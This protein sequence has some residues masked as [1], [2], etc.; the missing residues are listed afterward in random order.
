[1]KHQVEHVLSFFRSPILVILMGSIL[2]YTV[3]FSYFSIQR[4]TAFFSGFDL[5]NMDHTIWN[6]MQ[7]DFFT[8]NR[9]GSTFSRFSIHSDLILVLLAPFYFI[10]NDVRMLLVLQSFFLAL[11]AIPT[12]IIAKRLLKNDTFALLISLVYLLNPWLHWVNLYDFH[13]VALAIPLLLCVFCAAFTKKW[14]WMWVFAGLALATKESI[15]L[16]VGMLGLMLILFFREK[17]RGSIL[18]LLGFGWFF[19]SV[20]VI[21]P[22]FSRPLAQ[23]QH[24]ALRWYQFDDIEHD[25]V[26]T[27]SKAHVIFNKIFLAPDLPRYYFSLL[28]PFAFLPLIGFPW[29]LISLPT[30]AINTLSS[31]AQMRGTM[32]HYHSGIIPG[33][34]ISTILGLA[35]V[36]KY[37]RKI[38]LPKSIT[39]WLLRIP[40]YILV[41]ISVMVSIRNSPLPYNPNC[42]CRMFEVS[43]D[44][45]AFDAFLRSIPTD[46]TITASPEIRPHLTHR[47]HAYTIPRG[48]SKVEYIALIDQN[49]LVGDTKPK[50]YENILIRSLLKG[51][52]HDLVKQVGN[53]YV[54]KRKG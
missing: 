10:W 5:A 17:L 51:N 41:V 37:T 19:I 2:L 20:F 25:V 7:G 33:L 32:L 4:H 53:F 16:S 13:G 21:T 45:R 28:K 1:M 6:S 3:A 47:S 30:L 18:L 43:E 23:N 24:W 44:D 11:G 29:M 15:G 31:H 42:W 12:Y 36:Q 46:A 27:N 40:V 9:R 49:R 14:V 35:Y 38:N 50:G 22:Y 48:V 39:A 26:P 8:L 54:F 34:V 52:T